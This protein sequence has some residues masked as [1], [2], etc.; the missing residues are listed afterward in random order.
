M[1]H[2]RE[3]KPQFSRF[4]RLCGE[5]FLV[6]RTEVDYYAGTSAAAQR[7]CA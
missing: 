3:E 6:G 7:A 4:G 5:D 1:V 2:E